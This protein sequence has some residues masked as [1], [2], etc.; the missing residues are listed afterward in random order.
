ME[1]K[2]VVLLDEPR[3][4]RLEETKYMQILTV[5]F[6]NVDKLDLSKRKETWKN[7]EHNSWAEGEHI[8]RVQRTPGPKV[9]GPGG[10]MPLAETASIC[11]DFKTDFLNQHCNDAVLDLS[12]G[13]MLI[14][15]HL[16][17]IRWNVIPCS[18][19]KHTFRVI[20]WLFLDHFFWRES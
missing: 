2:R 9:Q 5:I 13:F 12:V 6:R 18:P 8:H 10:S 15:D 16:Y 3:I 11:V 17:L 20:I 14:S 19:L 1:L 4:G 7:K